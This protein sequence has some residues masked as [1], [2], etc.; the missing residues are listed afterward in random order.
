MTRRSWL[1]LGV[2]AACLVVVLGG[3]A[4]IS[5]T[6]LSFA[7]REEAARRQAIE[8]E[9]VRLALWRMDSAIAPMMARESARPYFTFAAFYPA[10]RPY[11]RMF[12]EASEDEALVPSPL[13][14]EAPERTLLHFRIDPAGHITSPQ[15]PEGRLAELAL[16]QYRDVAELESAQVRLVELRRM[17]DR[18]LLAERLPREGARVEPDVER[19]LAQN[20]DRPQSQQA[21]SSFEWQMRSRSVMRASTYNANPYALSQAAEVHETGE[22]RETGGARGDRSAARRPGALS[23]A[24]TVAYGDIR[25]GAVTPLWIEGSLFLVRRVELGGQEYLQGSWLDWPSI[26]EWLLEDVRDLLPNARLAAIGSEGGAEQTRRLASL[27]VHLIAGSIPVPRDAA[28]TFPVGLVLGIT[29]LGLLSAAVAAIAL[30][31]G[32]IALSERRATFVSSVTHELR[33]PLT[34]FRMYSEMLA[35]GMVTDEAQRKVYLETLKREAV[36]LGHLVENVLAFARIERGRHTGRIETL[37]LAGLLE[38]IGERLTDRAKQADMSLVVEEPPPALAIV[39]DATA[40]EQILFNLVD[41]ACKYAATATERTITL[42]VEPS[43]DHVALWVRD[44]GPGIP[45]A[46]RRRLF[47]PFSKSAQRAALTAPGVGLGLALS[48]RLARAM[49]GDLSLEA[50]TE[51]ASFLLTL[52]RAASPRGS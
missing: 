14:T 3:A 1:T 30:L 38:R 45:K 46:E 44:H 17:L 26:R 9:N 37:E 15:A 7:D 50:R 24:I 2:F 18:E 23:R 39:A 31:F 42:A 21:K 49:G 27:P 35:E 25:E 32:T 13:L 6:L 47:S 11:T 20:L 52:P 16:A 4:W 29:W 51:G 40:L 12:G 48:R 10:E 22:T 43:R 41:N 19:Q 34:T 36:R 28:D 33:T 8:E 5:A